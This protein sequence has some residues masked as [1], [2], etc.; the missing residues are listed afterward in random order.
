VNVVYLTV[1]IDGGLDDLR[2]APLEEAALRAGGSVAWRTSATAGRSYALLELP[3]GFDATE[4][5]A[6]PGGILYDRPVI[7]LA[8]SPAL[9]EALPPLIEALSGPGSPAGVL[10]CRPFAGGAVVEWDPALTHARVIIGLIDVE[11]ARF[12]CGRRMQLLSPLPAEVLA[13]IA[14]DGLET[15]QIAPQ[16]ILELRIDRA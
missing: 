4:I 5:A 15:P 14:A 6:P 3:D 13:S 16:R 9:S 12:A 8:V 7:A 1:S 2:R 11:L 10:A